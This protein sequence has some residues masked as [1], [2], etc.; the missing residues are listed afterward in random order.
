MNNQAF[1]F[2]LETNFIVLLKRNTRNSK[3]S[4][5]FLRKIIERNDLFK[6]VIN[7]VIAKLIMFLFITF[8]N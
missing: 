1:S 2:P 5:F 4:I 7:I 8:L 3:G 6:I